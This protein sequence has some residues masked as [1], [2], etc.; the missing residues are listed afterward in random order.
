MLICRRWQLHE[1]QAGVGGGRRG[2]IL[3]VTPRLSHTWTCWHNE[4]TC[5]VRSNN[6]R[7]SRGR[8][9][10]HLRRRLLSKP[11]NNI[12]VN[13]QYFLPN[14]HEP[15]SSSHH[16]LGQAQGGPEEELSRDHVCPVVVAE[17]A[18]SQQ[19]AADGQH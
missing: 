17:E 18:V 11:G 12:E 1:D 8:G 6:I 2:L 10:G 9:Q 14:L 13:C 19:V 5:R 3:V 4:V 7:A 15:G 16:K